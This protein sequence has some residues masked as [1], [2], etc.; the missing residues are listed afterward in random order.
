MTEWTEAELTVLVLLRDQGA[1]TTRRVILECGPKR[2]WQ[3]L[4]SGGWL[5]EFYTLYGSVLGLTNKSRHYIL[6]RWGRAEYLNAPSTCAN[7]AYEQDAVQLLRA[8]GY[9]PISFLL[10]TVDTGIGKRSR[11]PAYQVM[12]LPL[13]DLFAL[14]A[15]W[16]RSREF[17]LYGPKSQPA[18]I[19]YPYLYASIANG[20]ISLPQLKRLFRK[21]QRDIMRWR[22]PLLIAVPDEAP[23]RDY[24]RTINARAYDSHHRYY[25]CERVYRPPHLHIQLIVLP[26]PPS[27][28]PF[29]QPRCND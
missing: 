25:S 22:T 10:Q 17:N 20:G 8:H 5:N 16:D 21:H 12:Q 7:R 28:Q 26:L 6:T 13:D 14:E 27:I 15:A 19:G 2:Y 11:Q 3:S 24:V 18:A 1:L 23:C 4:L 29:N 9:T